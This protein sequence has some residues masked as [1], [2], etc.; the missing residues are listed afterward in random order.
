MYGRHFDNTYVLYSKVSRA[1]IDCLKDH[2][3]SKMQQD[4]W[5]L[6]IELKNILSIT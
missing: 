4:D 2:Y 1:S 3:R 5:K 6:I